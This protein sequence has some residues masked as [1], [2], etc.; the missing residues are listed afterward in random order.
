MQTLRSD[1]LAPHPGLPRLASA[2]K[3]LASWFFA[4]S[5]HA[6]TFCVGNEAELQDALTQSSDLGLHSGEANYIL[7]RHKA[8]GY[9]TGNAPFVYSSSA[10][11]SAS[12][13]LWIEGSYRT[14]DTACTGQSRFDAALSVLDGHNAT[15]V[16]EIHSK[17]NPVTVSFLTIQNGEST[18]DGAGLSINHLSSD[19][20]RAFVITNIIRNNHTTAMAG[21]LYAAARDA[22]TIDVA[23]NLIV[24][25]SADQ[26]DGAGRVSVNACGDIS[27]NTVTQNT[28][29]LDGG[30]GGLYFHSVG[31]CPS[32]ISNN[33]FWN[34]TA[35]GLYLASSFA[36]LGQNDYGTIGGSAPL[37]DVGNVSTNPLFVDAAS[38]NFHLSGNS[39]LI[40]LSPTAE[41]GFDLE[42]HQPAGYGN[43]DLGAYL[44]T[45]FRND[46]D[47]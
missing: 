20:G 38:G 10:A 43:A 35:Y 41:G 27:N 19:T 2:G 14:N 34:N 18:S 29:S 21:G 40:A 26:G 24:G 42:G 6:H 39:P 36:V 17:F 30:S 16:L 44:E 7:V 47:G 31:P 23:Y 46:F 33:I 15:A 25:N 9:Q 37:N 28:T 5:A 45:I 22:N 3:L 13:Y 1:Q 32:F 12:S 8:G 11:A 4:T